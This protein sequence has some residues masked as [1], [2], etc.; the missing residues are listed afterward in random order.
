MPNSGQKLERLE[1]RT[2]EW[3]AALL[4]YLQKLEKTKPVIWTGDLNVAHHDFDIHKRNNRAAGFTPAERANFTATVTTHGFIDVFHRLYPAASPH[5]FTYWNYKW[6]AREKNIG[7]RLD[8][9]VVSPPLMDSHVL[10][11]WI[12]SELTEG[13]K[14]ERRSDHAPI[15]LLLRK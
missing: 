12:G 11:T 13:S 9:F 1:Y 15:F 2:K 6:S 7:W 5:R 4:E 10:D 3:D 8:Y 14:G